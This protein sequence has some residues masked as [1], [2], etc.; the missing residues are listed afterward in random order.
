MLVEEVPK[1]SAQ[2]GSTVYFTSSVNLT[3]RPPSYQ[4]RLGSSNLAS[5]IS[6]ENSGNSNENGN[7]AGGDG[8]SSNNGSN[9]NRFA[10]SRPK[11]NYNLNHLMN[12]QTSVNDTSNASKGQL[13]SAQQIQ[14]ERLISRRIGELNKENN[15]SVSNFEIPKNFADSR[16]G[17][18]SG[19]KKK[20]RLG[21]TPLTKKILA[22]RRN[23]ALYF[24]EERNVLNVNTILS[25]NYQFVDELE[26]MLVES[27]AKRQKLSR[28]L[29]K[30]KVKLC[31][32]CGG[33]SGYARCEACGLFSCSVRCN[34]LHLDLRCV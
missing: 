19:D 10:K 4:D 29:V 33:N 5:S 17:T 14:I 2:K 3:A 22:A 11:I 18:L 7:G 13:K 34:K 16:N 20:A 28:S 1:T 25:L 21:N 31:C 15:G 9:G 32:I 27:S 8:S 23:L 26:P 12:A 6:N 24:E 30:P